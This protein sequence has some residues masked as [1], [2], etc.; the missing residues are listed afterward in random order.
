M[1]K[2]IQRESHGELQVVGTYTQRVDYPPLLKKGHK[3]GDK[4]EKGKN[5]M[6]AKT[7]YSHI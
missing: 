2:E 5:K 4:K 7:M 1:R 6:N 3:R